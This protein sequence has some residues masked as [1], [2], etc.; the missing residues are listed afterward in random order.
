MLSGWR[1]L[2]HQ[3][4]VNCRLVQATIVHLVAVT[5]AMS[6]FMPSAPADGPLRPHPAAQ[7]AGGDQIKPSVSVSKRHSDAATTTSHAAVALSQ[8]STTSISPE[9]TSAT[10]DPRSSD[11]SYIPP[12]GQANWTNPYRNVPK[13]PIPTQ[14]GGYGM[15]VYERMQTQPIPVD[16]QLKQEY[17]H[18]RIDTVQQSGW[19]MLWSPYGSITG[20]VLGSAA[21]GYVEKRFVGIKKWQAWLPVAALYSLGAYTDFQRCYDRVWAELENQPSSRA[22][23]R[24]ETKQAVDELEANVANAAAAKKASGVTPQQHA[25]SSAPPKPS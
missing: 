24:M 12:L 1:L 2:T 9:T 23:L 8:P 3:L 11:E 5:A 18:R 15:P 22:R 16:I 20:L 25:D 13:R 14:T 4:A 6:A 7:P 21:M 17:L 19:C 10:S